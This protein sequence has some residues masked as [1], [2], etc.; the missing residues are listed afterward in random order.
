MKDVIVNIKFVSYDGKFPNL[1]GG[2]LVFIAVFSSGIEKTYT[3]ENCLRPGGHIHKN[4][5]GDWESSDGP[6]EVISPYDDDMIYPETALFRNFTP[7]VME[8]L[9][10]VVNEKIDWGCCGGC[11]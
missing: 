8:Y 1:C 10:K 3:W 2:K 7:M 11:T 5:R 9:T 6:W 4:N